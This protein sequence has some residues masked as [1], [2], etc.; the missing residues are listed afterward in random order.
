MI[1]YFL[2][3]NFKNKLHLGNQNTF[4]MSEIFHFSKIQF[5]FILFTSLLELSKN[6]IDEKMNEMYTSIPHSPTALV[7]VLLKAKVE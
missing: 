7:Y 6:K 4:V 1:F 3:S 5:Y 2:K